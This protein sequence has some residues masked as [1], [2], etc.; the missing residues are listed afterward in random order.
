MS[1]AVSSPSA[2]VLPVLGSVIPMVRRAASRRLTWPAI[3]ASKVG[4]AESSKSAMKQDAPEFSALM[5]ILRSTGPVISTRRSV[6]SAGV[7]A[8]VHSASR[9]ALVS[10]R[11]AG[12]S[13]AS[14]R[15]WN[16]ARAASRRRRSAPK[17]RSNMATKA[18]ASALRISSRPG[19]AG[20]AISTPVSQLSSALFLRLRC[21]ACYSFRVASQYDINVAR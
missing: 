1:V 6:R 8:M 13:P 11:K 19:T 2:Y 15:A 9:I 20:P 3:I 16:A 12:F 10:G 5:I 14:M 18:Q 21:I 4:A 7:S 17:R